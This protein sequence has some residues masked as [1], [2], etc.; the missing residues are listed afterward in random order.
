MLLPTYEVYAIRYATVEARQRSENF[1]EKDPLH[2]TPMPMDYYVWWIQSGD[3]HFLVDTGFN[4]DAARRRGRT[5]LRCPIESLGELGVSPAAISDV[6]LTHLH[7]DHAGNIDKLPLARFH[8]Q[9][10]EMGYATG[11]YMGFPV[12]R[13]AY[14]ADDVTELVRRVYDGRVAF[15]DGD[16]ELAPG[17]SLHKIGGHTRGLQVVRV[18]T[19]RGWL[20]LASDASHFLDNIRG[21][22]PFPIVYNVGDMLEG[23][24]RVES[25]A[26]SPEHIIPGHDPKV[27]AI[28]P[29]AK[30]GLTD[31]VRL[32]L[33]QS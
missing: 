11:K 27:R 1:L 2:Q 20:V 6:V 14:S 10:A 29:V 30:D 4:A 22:A 9:E 21:R 15:Y 24:T 32:D 3:R 12:I 19:R 25:L 23:L 33:A 18:H 8:V 31:F 28:Y 5:L 26:D 13:N 17:L 7:Y 16:V